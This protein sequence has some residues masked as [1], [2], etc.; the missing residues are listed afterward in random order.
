MNLHLTNRTAVITGATKGIGLAVADALA[1][2]GCALHLAART[3]ADLDTVAE[4]LRASYGIPV[5]IHA[6]DLA[7]PETQE[8][9]AASTASAA[10]IV[11]NCAGN[12]PPGEL[13]TLS[14]DDWRAGWQ[15]KV[16]GTIHLNRLYYRAMKAR[17]RGVMRHLTLARNA[18][19][20]PRCSRVPTIVQAHFV[21][22]GNQG[23]T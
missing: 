20:R 16:F 8:A 23:S 11:V 10:D 2:E 18:V 19:R 14:D 5:D 13:D 9:L 4:R 17:R 12:I 3:E 1:A 6:L 21:P 7:L 15:L 22:S